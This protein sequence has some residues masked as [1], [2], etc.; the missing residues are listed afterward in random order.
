MSRL[1]GRADAAGRDGNRSNNAANL[2]AET[3]V[4]S[5][6][7]NIRCRTAHH[8]Q[9]HIFSFG[10]IYGD[11]TGRIY[12]CQF[13][14]RS[15]GKVSQLAKAAVLLQC[16]GVVRALQFLSL[17]LPKSLGVERKRGLRQLP[18]LTVSGFNGFYPGSRAALIVLRITECAESTSWR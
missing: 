3:G 14:S 9:I 15:E 17:S 13:R 5:E 7:S 16:T 8:G 12:N 18:S 6:L 2:I 4:Q 1:P 11:R 10:R